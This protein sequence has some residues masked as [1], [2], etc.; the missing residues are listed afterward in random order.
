[1]DTNKKIIE[2]K[3]TQD[4]LLKYLS[5]ER[6]PEINEAPTTSININPNVKVSEADFVAI[7]AQMMPMRDFY[8]IGTMIMVRPLKTTEIQAYSLVTEN[9][10]D[11][12]D[13]LNNAFQSSVRVK[14][15][16][17]EIKSYL[18]VK[19]G[20]RFYLAYKIRELTYSA[21]KV[22]T[23][24][25]SC[26][27]GTETTI[28]YFTHN[29]NL[30]S[31]PEPL[32]EY[33]D[34]Y[35]RC[36]VLPVG[37]TVYEIAPPSIGIQRDITNYIAALAK[38]NKDKKTTID[39]SFVK[40]VP[41]LIKG[42]SI[43]EKGIEAKIQ[44]FKSM[45]RDDFNDLDNFITAIILGVDTIKG[46]CPSCDSEVHT[47]NLFPYGFKSLLTKPNPFTSNN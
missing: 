6:K 28:E 16:N 35:K 42:N 15:P 24:K 33:Y 39:L 7:D 9:I 22:L 45:D 26:E 13:K 44:E 32:K 1:M 38:K 20:D 37:N 19:D 27:C 31:I 21:A 46:V 36:F 8:P 23:V 47:S 14:Y 5:Q 34:S 25:E 2:E 17:G 4:V 43:S 29:F 41:F 18:D 12:Y 30:L 40:T 11:V 10:A 3:D